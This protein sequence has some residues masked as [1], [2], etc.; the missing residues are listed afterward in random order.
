ME[1][2]KRKQ[3][4]SLRLGLPRVCREKYE[5][6][7]EF[8]RF[9]EEF[10][11]SNPKK[12]KEAVLNFTVDA[13]CR[14]VKH[15][16]NVAQLVTM[17]VETHIFSSVVGRAFVT[18]IEKLR[19]GSKTRYL[20]VAKVLR[21]FSEVT[22]DGFNPGSN[23]LT[24]V[25]VLV[26]GSQTVNDSE[27]S[28]LSE[29][30]S[31]A[32]VGQVCQLEVEGSVVHVMKALASQPSAAQSL[33]EDDSFMILFQMVANGSL[34]VFSRY[35]KGLV[36]L[37]SMQLHRHAMQILGL[38]L[39]NDNG[40]TA[41]YIHQHHLIKVLLTAVKD[42]NPDCGDPAYTV[43]I[44]DLLLECVELSYRPEAG[45]IRLREEIH[46]A[47]GYHL[48]VQ[49]AL[50]LSS[51][52]QSQ[53]IE[54]IYLKSS[55]NNNY[56]SGGSH[57]FD[58]A[59]LLD[60]LVNLAQTGPAEEKSSKYSQIKASGHSRSLSFSADRLGNEIWE[61]SNNK[62]KDLEAVQMLQD[63]FLKAGSTDLQAEVLNR[64]FKIFSSH[65]E[66]YKLCQQ[67][68]SVPLFIL[69]MAGFP[70]ALHAIIL[71]ILEYGVTVVNYVPEQELLSLC[72]LLQQPITSE[73]KLTILS[74]FHKFLSSPDQHSGNSNQLAS[75]SSLGTFK[76]Y[77]DSEDVI[78]ASPKLMESGTG[79]FPIFEAE[80]TIIIAWDCMVSL[81]KK[82]EA[83]QA[84]FRS[85]N[86]ATTILPSLM[87]NIHR[88]GVIRV[89]SCLI[90]GD[91][92]LAH[93]EELGALVEVLKSRMVTGVN[94]S[95]RGVF[96]EATGFSLLLTTLHSFQ[97]DRE[98]TEE[99]SIA[100]HIKVFTYLIRLVTS[101]VCGNAINRTKLHAII[102]SQ[103]FYDLLCESG[104]LCVECEKQVI[105]LLLEL[106]LE[107][108]LPP[109]LTPESSTSLYAVENE[110]TSFLLT[111]SSGLFN[112]DKERVYNA[113]AVR[114][115]I[116]SLLFTPKVQLCG[117]YIG[118]DSPLPLRLICIPF[119]CFEDCGGS[120]CAQVSLGERS[121]CPATGYSFV[122]WFQF[123][124]FF[125]MSAKD[126]EPSKAELY[127]QEDGV[128]TLA[129]SNL[130]SLLFSGLELE[131]GRWHHLAVI[132]SKP[133]ALAGLFQASVAYVYLDGKLRHT[134]KLGYSP[135]PV[136]KPLQVTLGGTPINRA[137]VSDLTL[138]LRSC[139]L[140]EEVLTPGCICFMYIL[141]R[142]YRGLFQDSDLLRFVPNQAC[143]GGSMAILESLDADLPLASNEQ[144]LDG[145]S[146]QGDSKADGSGIVWDLD[147]LGN[148]SFQRKKL[149]FAFDGTYTEAV[150]ASGTFLMLNMVDPM[151]AAASPIGGIP[152]FGHLYGHIYI[153]RQ[154]VIGDTICPVGG[155][156]VILALVEAAG[157][158]DM[159]HLALN[160]FA[161]ALH[162]NPEN[163]CLQIPSLFDSENSFLHWAADTVKKVKGLF[164]KTEEKNLNDCDDASSQHTFSS[165]PSEHEQSSKTSISV[166]SFPQAQVSTS[167]E[168]IN[169]SLK[170]MIE[171]KAESKITKSQEEL[172]KSMDI[173]AIHSLDG[174]NVDLV[175]ATSS[176]SE[177][178][179]NNIKSLTP[180]LGINNDESKTPTVPSLSIESSVSIREF[181]P[182]PV[183][184]ALLDF[185]RELLVDLIIEQMKAAQVV[186]SVLEMVPLYVE[187]KPVLV[188]QGLCLSRLMNF[189]E[190][191]L[192]RDDEEDEKKLDKSKWSSNLDALCWMVVD[193]LYMGAF[194]QPGGVL[195]TLE[196]FLSML[197]LANKDG[198][199]GAAAPTGK[200]LSSIAR[201]SRQHDA[202]IHSILKNTNRMI[203]Y[204][205]LPSFLITIGEDDLLAS[206]GLLTE[207]KKRSSSNSSL[208]D[209][210]MD[211]CT[212]LQLLVAHRRVIFCPSNLDT[213]LNCCICINL[214]CLLRDQRHNVQ[215]MAIDI[216]KYL[217]GH[218]RASL[219]DLLV[220]K[221]NQG[222]PLDVLHAGLDKLSIGSLSSFFE[223]LLNSEQIV[224]KVLEQ[225]AAILWVQY[226]A[227]SAKFPGVRI[228]G[229]ESCHKREMGRKS[230]DTA[231]LDLR[232]WEQV[233]ERT[234]TLLV[235]RDA[236]A[237]ELRVVRQDKYGW[238]LHA[239]S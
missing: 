109:C 173:D 7:L 38:L 91:V 231:K 6:E 170:L 202:Y 31:A 119:L 112:P 125:R 207:P 87:S 218:Q 169:I 233:N 66:N 137:R 175:S 57:A 65:L 198:R 68:R 61:H 5:L 1:L 33:I 55:F 221:P 80:G 118:D 234:Y 176:S 73:L 93:P 199:I 71:K 160:L 72:C 184:T 121:W 35:K 194:P 172:K 227:G 145:A 100:V 67:L 15:H 48:L 127:L 4:I 78:I 195:R 45:G 108:V 126:I 76:N 120:W 193:R 16:A 225:S 60:A 230:Q 89:L 107:I 32:D 205:F 222:Q 226:I 235:L 141:G 182:S 146:K 187:A 53:G 215:N 105:Q 28:L 41:K 197:Q 139:F 196:F 123:K 92:M 50:V 174:D 96:G 86:G 11:S 98:H 238:V 167:S 75:K 192:L 164:V 130:C 201:G 23:L 151:S 30:D 18:D 82:A 27:E 128:L 150:R 56:G 129:T 36:S 63:I 232:Y 116:H 103:T 84:A 157:T 19:I 208:E 185:I 39:V 140:F 58:D 69:N 209:S 180:W 9:W 178:N 81:I 162:Q 186:Q 46:N 94:N 147:R 34:T 159:L 216:V 40:S 88:P 163:V 85:A 224:N 131:E 47:H 153:C 83:N 111:T 204:C 79:K 155:M 8:K 138:R 2:E 37:H 144:K 158:R 44:V 143:G 220:S 97:G 210:G 132:H 99:S 133:N 134:G 213:D 154:C 136:G 206:L 3:I 183:T 122:C 156:A 25:E 191:H 49:F 239:E 90:T 24:A 149:I 62:V 29:K 54:S 148:L 14:L 114:V 64:M 200:G 59:V 17:L 95:A 237:T 43:G 42:F 22:K 212:V 181:D 236:M 102:S 77:L 106:A 171:D 219:E 52:H 12:E 124:N 13:F 229:M 223:W 179:F 168:E 211:I 74:F 165:L 113:G 166:G 70:P 161:C 104:L 142:G 135:S 203:L 110:S 177:L 152:C 21:F 189:L 228:K 20:D 214:F 10:R 101:G 188:F 115:L 190:R 217:L 51:M 26:S 117:T